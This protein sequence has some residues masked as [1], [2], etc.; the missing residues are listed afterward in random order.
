MDTGKSFGDATGAMPD[1]ETQS[2]DA[3]SDSESDAGSD[4]E[5]DSESDAMG[6]DA[7]ED[8]D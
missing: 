2:T 8:G 7:R 3:E 4:S 1:G 5:S 6:A